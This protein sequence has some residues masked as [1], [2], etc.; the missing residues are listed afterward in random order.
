MMKTILTFRGR[1]SVVASHTPDEIPW[2]G[3]NPQPICVCCGV[4]VDSIAMLIT[5]TRYSAG[6]HYIR[7]YRF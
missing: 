7:G 4:G 1:P 2:L 5:S 6:S 3:I